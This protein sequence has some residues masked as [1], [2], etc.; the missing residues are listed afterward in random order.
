MSFYLL[1]DLFRHLYMYMYLLFS[2]SIL[3]DMYVYFDGY[4]RLYKRS[5]SFNEVTVSTCK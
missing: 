4:V 3:K 1:I 2:V 5:G